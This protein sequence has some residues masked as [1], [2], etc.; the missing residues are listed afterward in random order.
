[1]P[2][3]RHL[4]STILLQYSFSRMSF[5]VIPSAPQSI[6]QFVFSGS[7]SGPLGGQPIQGSRPGFT[8]HYQQRV[9]LGGGRQSRVPQ[10][11]GR[12]LGV[13]GVQ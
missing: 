11:R 3:Q 10:G 2:S 8:T 6:S 7:D 4:K 13:L 12:I 5:L 1:M 9:Q